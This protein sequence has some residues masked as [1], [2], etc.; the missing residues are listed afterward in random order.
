M[1]GMIMPFNA[2]TGKVLT[3]DANGSA[4]WQ[5]LSTP[6]PP[7]A[8][9]NGNIGYG[10]WGDCAT[11]GNISAYQ[12][13]ADT[14][15]NTFSYL[16]RAVSISGNFA[17]AGAPSEDDSFY[18][19]GVAMV[20]FFDGTKWVFIQKLTDPDPAIGE[21]FGVNVAFSGN[22]ALVGSLYD[23]VDIPNQGSVSVFQFDGTSWVFMQRIID[24]TGGMNFGFGTGLAISGDFIAVGSPYDD[25]YA[26][27]RGSVNIFQLVNGVW[28]WTEE[29]IDSQGADGDNFGTTVAMDGTHLAIGAP[30]DDVS[31]NDT[32]GSVLTYRYNGANW[33]FGE[34]LTISGAF[35]LFGWSIDLEGNQL[36]IGAYYYQS[37]GV[38]NLYRYN[39]TS[40]IGSWIFNSEVLDTGDYFGYAVCISGNYVLIGALYTDIAPINN[41][42]SAYLYQKIGNGWQRIQQLTDPG[43]RTGDEFGSSVS[44]DSS[45]KRFVIGATGF[46]ISAGKVVFGKIN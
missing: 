3:S 11:N 25:T 42:G 33:V 2:G 40:W 24:P 4:S 39:G 41:I 38:V 46:A 22:F 12:P 20:Y 43:R 26:N 45:N 27:G 9:N 30:R 34:K 10:V 23:D 15:I 36:L 8:E 35:N 44:L 17:I 7:P 16:G 19:Q 21:Q 1:N 18:D 31:G 32:Q 29:L 13:V 5:M 37:K 28:V 6:P 14:S